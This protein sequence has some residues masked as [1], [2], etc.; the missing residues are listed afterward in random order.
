MCANLLGE[1]QAGYSYGISG[2]D[3]WGCAVSTAQ[4][5]RCIS[6]DCF[7]TS[8]PMCPSGKTIFHAE[9]VAGVSRTEDGRFFD[10]FAQQF[11]GTG[12]RASAS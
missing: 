1:A 12:M 5:S 9:C 7:N 11:A 4:R 3:E 10:T 2:Y 6:H 8:V